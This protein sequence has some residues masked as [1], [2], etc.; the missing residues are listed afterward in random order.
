LQKALAKDITLRVHGEAG[1]EKAIKSTEF[2]FG[3]TGIEFLSELNDEEVLAI[4]SGV[5]NF[6]IAKSEIEA[7][8]NIS[9]LLAVKTAV[10]PSKGEAKK[11]IQGGGVAINKE[12]VNTPDDIFAS[13]K[14]INNKYLVA[15][16]GKRNY[17]LI[18]AE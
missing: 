12:K 1:F 11:M 8:I 4:F 3:N 7:G 13:D 6:T 10:F 18:V 15:Q 16:K 2:L 14:L 5:P 9:D 17:F